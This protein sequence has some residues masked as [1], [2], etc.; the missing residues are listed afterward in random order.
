MKTPAAERPDEHALLDAVGKIYAAALDSTAW[1]DAV[2]TVC[3]LVGAD[4]GLL[5]VTGLPLAQVA[6]VGFGIDPERARTYVEHYAAVDLY[7][8]AA[9]AKAKA[10][11]IIWDYELI[12]PDRIAGTEIFEDYLRPQGIFGAGQSLGGILKN[13]ARE[14]AFIQVV[15]RTRRRCFAPSADETLKLLLPHVRRAVDIQTRMGEARLAEVTLDRLQVG[16]T[17]L[18]SRGRLLRMNRAAAEMVAAHDGLELRREGLHATSRA[19]HMAL[20]RLIA[21]AAA[22][23]LGNSAPGG[24]LAIRRPSGRRPLSLVA[25]PASPSVSL[26]SGMLGAVVVLF[27][28]DPEAGPPAAPAETLSVLYGLTPAEARTALLIGEG[29]A[30]KEV[31][32][33]LEISVDTVR[34]VLKRVFM[35]TGVDRQAALARLLART[36]PPLRRDA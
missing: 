10:G 22:P 34:T 14:L 30:P 20:E 18:D 28:T 31:A 6:Y 15:S 24:A 3:R 32:Q 9:R 21:R 11:D 25:V 17:F 29:R 2:A 1:G 35:K 5:Q 33:A 23:G 36:L 12:P 16:V 19:E 26:F 8:Q 13:D 4:A 27:I 7:N